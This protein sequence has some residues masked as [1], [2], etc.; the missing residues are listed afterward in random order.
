MERLVLT[1][2]LLAAFFENPV[3]QVFKLVLE[4]FLAPLQELHLFCMLFLLG[5]LS[6]RK[7]G[8]RSRKLVPLTLQAGSSRIKCPKLFGEYFPLT[9]QAG[10]FDLQ[11]TQALFAISRITAVL[12]Y[13]GAA[14]QPGQRCADGKSAQGVN[15]GRFNHRQVAARMRAV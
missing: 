14:P 12:V 11:L 6:R 4:L 13:L 9:Q 10:V 3:G 7:T 15:K 8:V 2:E 5:A 1:A